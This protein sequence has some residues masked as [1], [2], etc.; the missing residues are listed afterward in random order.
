MPP[1][2]I[3][4]RLV[5]CEPVRRLLA[6]GLRLAELLREA[7]WNPEAIEAL[8]AWDAAWVA[9]FRRDGPEGDGGDSPTSVAD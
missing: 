9:A 8:D 7:T 3:R 6:A 5:E 1:P 4:V 2:E